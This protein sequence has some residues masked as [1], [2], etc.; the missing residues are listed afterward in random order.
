MMNFNISE[1]AENHAKALNPAIVEAGKTVG[2][3]ILAGLSV[4]AIAIYTKK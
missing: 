4:V 2:I 3:Y 1:V